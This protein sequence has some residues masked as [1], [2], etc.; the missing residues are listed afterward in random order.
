MVFEMLWNPAPVHA[1]PGDPGGSKENFRVTAAILP[2]ARW[3][4]VPLR[5]LPQEASMEILNG[6]LRMSRKLVTRCKV[7]QFEYIANF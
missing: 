4:G 7:R 1:L 3:T 5:C 2:A 6:V